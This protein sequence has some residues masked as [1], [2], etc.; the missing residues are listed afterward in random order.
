MKEASVSTVMGS[1]NII[2]GSGRAYIVLP[3]GTK[4]EISDALYSPKS[5]R[6][7]L[8]FKDIR[9][10]GYHIETMSEGDV[11]YLH[12]TSNTQGS[13]KIVERLPAF[14]TGLYHTNISTIEANVVVNQKFT[15]NFIV[16]H[17]RLGHPGT[18]MMRKIITNS[19]G[20]SLQNQKILPND[21]TCAACSQ[22]KLI[23][24]PSPA[25]ITSESINFLE[26]IQGD[27]CGPIH[28]PCGT[29]RYFMVLID[30][31]TR[32]SHV[33]L[34][35]TRN[36]AFA[37]LLAQLI[38]LRAHFPDF[39]LKAIRL[40]N[41]GEFTSQAFNDYCMSIGI[42]VEHPVAHV[43]TQNG[44]AESLI[45]RLQMIARPLL[46]RS[47]LLVSAWGHAILHAA[48]LIRIRPT[49]NHKFS[50]SQLILGQ[51]PNIS[52]LKI[53]GCAVY[54]PI[55]P[56][57][58]SKMGPQ[59]RLG[60]Y[61]GY[62][63]P[64]IIKYL[65]PSTGDLFKARFADCHFN[66]SVFPTL[67]GESKQLG[68]ELS[69]NELSLNYLDPRTKECELEVQKIIHLQNLA[70]QLPEAFADP[71][72]V[73]KSHI[74]AENAPIRINVSEGHNQI[75]T[76][77]KARQKRGRPIG[78][79]DKNPRKRKG[80]EIGTSEIEETMNEKSPEETLHMTEIQVPENEEISTN[81]VMSGITWN[82]KQID[83]DEIFAYNV[84]IDIM[85]EDH[86][87]TSIAECTQ[88]NDWPKWN[89][90]IG[91][92]RTSLGKREVFGPVVRY[93]K[94]SNQ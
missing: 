86:E 35:S 3:M 40:D 51:E 57:Q 76:E 89:E 54:V 14:S 94:V 61:V 22:G 41:A 72:R 10:N 32:W 88:R 47:Q 64:S 71:K 65:E 84:A 39:P 24:R 62:D 21:F 17:D 30:A 70:N 58:R 28:P 80:A 77:S 8:S 33:S 56:P 5:N 12:I 34:L 9:K 49:S 7:L 68:K 37:R 16:W 23:I 59:R 69:W 45:K 42:S 83:V 82:R 15:E 20:H 25:K 13:K 52:H 50:P 63:S 53:F 2:E 48:T 87:P 11:E 75:A 85:D 1:A 36:L 81:Y 18:T 78:S 26:R 6:N 74:P 31:S 79:K 91:A 66:E 43:H 67:G 90:A 46:M 44:L 73:T 29:F 93:L 60:I 92:E 19:C 27:I 55:A 4:L 38:R